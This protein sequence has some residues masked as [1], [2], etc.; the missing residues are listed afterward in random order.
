MTKPYF[1]RVYSAQPQYV[2]GQI[3]TV[4]IDIARGRNTFSIVGLPD[5]AVDEARDRVGAALRHSDFPN[6]KQGFFKTV[7]SLAPPNIRKQGLYFDLAIAIGYLLA[8][9]EL[10][11]NTDHIVFLGS[12][13]LN[14]DVVPISGVLVLVAAARDAGFTHVVVPQQNAQE[15]SYIDGIAIIPVQNVHQ[16]VDWLCGNLD[17]PIYI[18]QDFTDDDVFTAQVDMADVRGQDFAKRALLIAAV[19]G[20][21]VAMYGPPGTGKTML[22]KAF[23]GILP[24]LTNEESLTVTGIHSVANV[25]TKSIVTQAPFRSPHHTASYVSII[26]GGSYPKPGEVTLAHHGVLFL[27]EFPEFE[28]RVIE[29]LRQPM[30]DHVVSI[31]R[32]SGSAKFPAAFLLVAA[33]NPCPCGFAGTNV[34]QCVCSGFQIERYQKRLSG[35]I[36]DRIDIWTAVEHIEYEQLRSIPKDTKTS[37]EYAVVVQKSRAI[38][39]QRQGVLNRYL[40]AK[41]LD[42]LQINNDAHEVF[43]NY[44]KKFTLSPRGCHKVLR[45]ARSIADIDEVT[46]IQTVHILEAFQFRNKF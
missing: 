9:G 19:G 12:L 38:Q 41:Q 30:E 32:A 1:A 11:C 31:S 17:V 18:K 46:H 15:A 43:L 45:V 28:S 13:A 20:H 33:F 24:P 29:S 27:D 14:G 8:C 2:S 35:P 23:Q 21:N 40:S 42:N 5:K 36:V 3:I 26:G 22:A 6:P 10:D 34:K 37:V 4:E 44:A 39:L 25:L 7:A 16:V